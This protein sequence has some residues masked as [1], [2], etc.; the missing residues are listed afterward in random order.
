M[1]EPFIITISILSGGFVV[2]VLIKLKQ[3][4]NAINTFPTPEELAAE[5]VKI[6]IPLDTLPPDLKQKVQNMMG[7]EYNQQPLPP[8]P[9]NPPSYMG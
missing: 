4:E 6:K 2:Y 9:I 1:I 8:L 3:L 5:I 7:T